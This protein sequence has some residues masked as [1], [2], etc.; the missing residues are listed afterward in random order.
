MSESPKATRP[1]SASVGEPR[2]PPRSPATQRRSED[3]DA[4]IK[5][6]IIL[7]RGDGL[8]AADS[9]GFSDPF[10]KMQ[11]NEKKHKSKVSP[12]AGRTA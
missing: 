9:N 6:T 2:T 10:V 11:L 7:K 12:A 1:P 8:L 3:A 4:P 5:V